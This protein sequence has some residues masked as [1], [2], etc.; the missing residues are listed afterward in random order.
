MA[1]CSSNWVLR[2]R[3][4][5]TEK[6]V[7]VNIKGKCKMGEDEKLFSGFGWAGIH[8]GQKLLV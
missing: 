7:A 2:K 5:P 8:A 1:V 3:Q 6:S 4:N